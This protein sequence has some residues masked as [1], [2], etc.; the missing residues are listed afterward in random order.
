MMVPAPS[1]TE[2]TTV[3]PPLPPSRPAAAGRLGLRVA[4]FCA[5]AL[6]AAQRSALRAAVSLAV[7]PP[8]TSRF[9]GGD[10]AAGRPAC[11][12]DGG[13]AVGAGAGGRGVG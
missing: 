8:R 12:G 7:A 6:C 11:G 10:M 2:K 5:R 3:T 9:A 13:R 1:R 4:A